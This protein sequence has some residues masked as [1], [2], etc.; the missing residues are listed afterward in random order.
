MLTHGEV[1]RLCFAECL[2]WPA[3][4]IAHTAG[5]VIVWIFRFILFH[6]RI[7]NLYQR[8]HSNAMGKRQSK[9]LRWITLGLTQRRCRVF[10]FDSSI[11]S[12][13]CLIRSHLSYSWVNYFCR[14]KRYYDYVAHIY[15]VIIAIFLAIF[16][17]K[18]SYKFL[19]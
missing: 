5:A 7:P 6:C 3:N 13:I 10:L 16:N 19:L 4:C 17:V 14:T 8:H 18:K 12:N 2:L 1:V 9:Y 15:K 11:W